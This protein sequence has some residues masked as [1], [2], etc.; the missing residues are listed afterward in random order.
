M[1]NK[2]QRKKIV[3]KKQE[4]FLSSVGYSKKQ[5]KTISTTDRAKVVKK[6][7]YKKKKRDKYHQARSMGFGSKEANKMSSW[8]DSRFI[9]YIEEFNS[10][11]MIVMYKDVTEET[12]SEAL[13]MIKNHT[14]RRSTSNLLRSIKGWLSVDKNQGYIGG[15]EIQVGKKDEIDFHLYAYKQR[16]YLQAY[17]GQGLQLKPLL[18]LLENMMVLLYMVEAKDQFVEDLCTNLRKLPYEQAHINANYIEE[19]FITDRSDLHF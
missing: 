10:Y 1:A 17:R 8:S 6:E 7:T 2:R 3:K 19:E 4:S 9:K 12:D 14:K 16:K 5:M 15:Y 18:N 11:Y 13:H